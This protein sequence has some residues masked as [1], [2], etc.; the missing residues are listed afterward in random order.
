MTKATI[1]WKSRKNGSTAILAGEAGQEL[2]ERVLKLKSS[3]LND[4]IEVQTA[5]ISRRRYM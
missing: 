4:L 2:E 5:I 1:T 3:L